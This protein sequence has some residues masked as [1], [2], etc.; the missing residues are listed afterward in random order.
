MMYDYVIEKPPMEKVLKHSGVKGM[1]WKNHKYISNANGV[2]KYSTSTYTKGDPDFDDSNYSEKNRIG[3]TDFFG[4]KNKDGK[5][6]VV[7]ED[8][9]WVMPNGKISPELINRLKNFN[10]D[11][12]L[13]GEEWN[14]A[15]TEAVTGN[16]SSSNSKKPNNKDLDD[17]SNRVIRGEFKNGEERKKLLGD[18]Y[19]SVQDLVNKK[20]KKR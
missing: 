16:K 7:T 9:K 4:F 5:F 20:L 6:V 19:R 13:R 12:K 2:Y 18:A 17:L 3:D 14:K 11:G 15:A 1:K 8:R 10:K